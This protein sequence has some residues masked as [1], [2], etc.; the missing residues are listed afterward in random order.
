MIFVIGPTIGVGCIRVLYD[1]TFLHKWC[2]IED[3]LCLSFSIYVS[4]LHVICLYTFHRHILYCMCCYVFIANSTS[5][6]VSDFYEPVETISLIST[7]YQPY[8]VITISNHTHP[9]NFC[10][11]FSLNSRP[12]LSMLGKQQCWD[13]LATRCDVCFNAICFTGSQGSELC[14]FD[15]DRMMEAS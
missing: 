6:C 5:N 7:P 3:E 12:Q 10:R 9:N 2:S 4:F 11:I 1:L 8:H 14:R 15:G 13:H